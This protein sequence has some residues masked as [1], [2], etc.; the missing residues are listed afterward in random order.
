MIKLIGM[1]IVVLALTVWGVVH[2]VKRL[3]H[4]DFKPDTD[5]NKDFSKDFK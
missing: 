3:K 4:K 5:F 1:S 2:I